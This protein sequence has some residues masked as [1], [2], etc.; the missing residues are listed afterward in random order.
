MSKKFLSISFLVLMFLCV[1]LTLFPQSTNAAESIEVSTVEDL[2]NMSNNVYQAVTIDDVKQ[3]Y[4]ACDPETRKYSFVLGLVDAATGTQIVNEP[5]ITVNGAIP[6]PFTLNYNSLMLA[7][8]PMGKGWGHDYETRIDEQQDGSIKL[9]W[10]ANRCNTF[11]LTGVN[12]YTSSDQACRCDKLIKNVDNS[13]DLTRKDQ[14]VYKFDTSGKIIQQLNGHGQSLNFGYNSSNHLQT[15]TEPLSGRTLTI[16]CNTANLIACISDGMMRQ[17]TF[18]YD[19]QNNMTGITYP[20]NKTTTFTYDSQGQVLSQ[21][22]GEGK[23]VFLDNYD[24]QGRVISQKDGINQTSTLVY[25]T[26]KQ[27]GKIVTT[28]INKNG[29]SKTYIHNSKYEL[30]QAVDELNHTNIYTYDTN[31]N[32]TS[33]TDAA[34]NNTIM[35]YD[36]RSNLLTTTDVAGHTTTMGYDDKNNLTSITD[37]N[38]KTTTSS[39]DANNNLT[40]ATD[41]LNHITSYSYDIN[42]LLVSETLPRLGQTT[43]TYENGMLKTIT[44]PVGVTLSYGYDSAGRV[45]SITNANNKTSTISY[46][47]RDNII[48]TRDPLNNTANFTYDS[49]GN[50]LTKTDARGNTTTYAY[51]ANLKLTSVTDALSNI[52]RYEYDPEGNLTKTTDARGNA[53]TAAYDDKGRQ[54]S[55][56]NLL[57]NTSKVEYDA[58]GNITA[59]YDALNKKAVAISYDKLYNPL[60]VTDALGNTTTNEYD[61]LSRLKKTSSPLNQITQY[62]YD[63]LNRLSQSTDAMNGLASQQYDDDGNHTAMIDPANN[64]LT[65]TYD[66]AG[67]L[68]AVSSPTGSQQYA[69]NQLGYLSSITNGRN[70]SSAYVYDDAGRLISKT[71]S[72]G[73]IAYTYD[74]NGNV[75]TVSDTSGTISREYDA[76][77][78][79]TRYTDTRGNNIQ[80]AY[81]QV[82]NMTLLTYP[83]GK[84]VSYSYDSSN[85]LIQVTDWA[86]R[87]TTYIYNPNGQL[88]Q[89]VRPDGSTETRTYDDNGRIIQQKDSTKN[90]E[91]ISQNDLAYDS[92]GRIISSSPD[93]Q[94]SESLAKNNIT[95]TTDNR[96]ASINGISVT[97][98]ADGNMITGPLNGQLV[99]FI[100]DSRNRLSSIGNTTYAYDAENNRIGVTENGIET[101]YTINPHTQLSQALVRTTPDGNETYYIYGLGLIGQ[102]ES[103]GYRNYHYDLRGSTIALTDRYGTITDTYQYGPYGELVNKNGTCS[104]PFLYNGRDGVMTDNNGLY[105]MRARYY[106]TE[107]LRFI[108]QDVLI[109]KISDSQSLN[110]YAYVNGQPISFIDPFGLQL[111]N[112]ENLGK[113]FKQTGQYLVSREAGEAYLDTIGT[114]AEAHVIAFSMTEVAAAAVVDT[115]VVGRR[116]LNTASKGGGNAKSLFRGERSSVT[117]DITF[118]Q[119]LLPKG[120]HGNLEQH[121]T[122]N[123]TA[124]NFISTTSE[125]GIA[126]QFAG[127]NGYVYEIETTNYIDVNK[128]LGAKSPFPEQIEHA[129]PG[130]VNPS[131]IKGVWVMKN[132]V[133]T[134]EFIPNPGFRG[135]K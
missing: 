25:D 28:V 32:R 124:G 90:G 125:R 109:G 79:I 92:A 132:S 133:P 10:T 19:A 76:L 129:I 87:T 5:I 112:W 127:K 113:T 110:R 13:F 41:T 67:R 60:T 17:I 3:F 85:R 97:Y 74:A 49:N 27:P 61:Q 37:T 14:S 77:N 54:I 64:T 104:I 26:G 72:G 83:D 20:D 96:L 55:I 86:G 56:T 130:G 111:M 94:V 66:L 128:V 126:E 4:L 119:G 103:I 8:G 2:N 82:G 121:I 84:Q 89:T 122:S 22:D 18:S 57:G 40:S 107:M 36:N 68:T 88:T 45:A 91:V 117:P 24:Q 51:D 105:Y 95:Y 46:D 33:I 100:F 42:G 44:D 120:T 1:N 116:T 135:V 47:I 30:E 101:Q 98:D 115:A 11:N 52:T 134:G 38:N 108:N 99:S 106:S 12:Q 34:A 39:Y 62:N 118:E 16:T 131:Q 43:Y 102:E 93:L 50:L 78:R 35:T 53:V 114:V 23:Q 21:I 73:T 71:D 70:Q 6:I 80:Y 29:K 63:D 48:Q 69:C 81:D 9:S 75:L 58:V 123:T 7:E 59:Q 31:G 15:I 65:A